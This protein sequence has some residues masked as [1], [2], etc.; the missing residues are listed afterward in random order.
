MS[1]PPLAVFDH[2]KLL[3]LT[4]SV[5]SPTLLFPGVALKPDWHG[6]QFYCSSPSTALLITCSRS[7][8]RTRPHQNS[9][10][11][12]TLPNSKPS[13]LLFQVDRLSVRNAS[14]LR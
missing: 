8:F 10:I 9:G 6:S 11:L 1:L 3:V 4:L 7:L 12:K 13:A 5:R 2:S 14:C